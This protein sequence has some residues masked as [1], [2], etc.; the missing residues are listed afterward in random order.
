MRPRPLNHPAGPLALPASAQVRAWR[1]ANRRMRWGIPA[2]HF[3]RLPPPP[4]LER[5]ERR[6]GFAG[7]VLCYGFGEGAG[8]A[9]DPV[10]S[11]RRAWEYAYRRR[12]ETLWRSRR[13]WHCEYADP[14][15]VDHW[16]LR[17]GAPPRPRGFYWVRFH[18]GSE[19]RHLTVAKFRK[20]LQHSTG[21]GPEGLQMV[22][23]TH[24]HLAGFMD[25]R[26][27]DFMALADFDIAPY[28]YGDFFEAPQVFCS[29]GILGL[30]VGNIDGPYPVFAIPKIRF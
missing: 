22:C 26:R 3:R 5:R 28:G 13:I 9:S 4:E 27:F 15:Q 10:L 24:P 1:R 25:Q 30:G 8:G 20:R 16:R 21:C 14:R 12:K 19:Y 23:I 29:Q 7:V 18:S 11:A 2:E 17:P 6:E